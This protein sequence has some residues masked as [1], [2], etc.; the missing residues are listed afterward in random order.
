MLRDPEYFGDQELVLVYIA[1][2]L[3]EAR[4][5]E[6]VLDAASVDY[7]VVPEHYTGGVFFS[8]RRVGAFFYVSPLCESQARS[9][10]FAAGLIPTSGSRDREDD[11]GLKRRQDPS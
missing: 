8:S 11:A 9:A 4:G 1:R 6:A 3:Q 2:R 7:T 10:L 5:V